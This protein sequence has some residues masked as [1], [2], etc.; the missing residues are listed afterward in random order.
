MIK[1]ALLISFLSVFALIV[2]GQDYRDILRYSNAMPLGTA[3]FTSMG[4]A[5]SAL[6]GDMSVMAYNPAGTGIYRRSDI[7]LT[8]GWTSTNVEST[9]NGTVIEAD[10][11]NM[12]LSNIGFV[13]ANPLR[14]DSEWKFVN[15][16]I[17][18]NQLANFDRMV[19]MEGYN[20]DNSYLD[21]ETYELNEGYVKPDESPFFNSTVIF[22][23][24]VNGEISFY[25]DYNRSGLYGANITKSIQERGRIGE[26]NFNIS[27]NYNDILFIGASVGVESINYRQTSIYSEY[28]TAGVPNIALVN[29]SYKEHFYTKGSGANLK[30]GLIYKPIQQLRIG[31]SLRTPTIYH[32]TDLYYEE[33]TAAIATPDIYYPE[34]L[35]PEYE[36][37]WM[38]VKPFVF[39][40]SGAVV[41]GKYGTVSAE[42]DVLDYGKMNLSSDDYDFKSENRVIKETFE[43]TYNLR[44]GAE[45]RAGLLTLRGGFAFYQSPYKPEYENSYA[46]TYQIS[47]GAG[48]KTERVYFDI[49]Y[50]YRTKNEKHYLYDMP[51]TTVDIKNTQG[52]FLLTAGIRF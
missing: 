17:S 24:T 32:L 45:V 51:N 22:L 5:F 26:W 2:S 49:A 15:I 4:G 8:L 36:S 7:G 12:H 18:Y 14:D 37:S 44:T 20:G 25:N 50:L 13:V 16:G 33:L 6:G 21:I 19:D 52:T 41:I 40:G 35:S 39:T 48:M 43:R 9:Y 29:F 47:G 10:N 3:R 31:A 1:K 42:I 23:D 11:M 38:A 30:L 46:H 28:P 27:A 34:Y